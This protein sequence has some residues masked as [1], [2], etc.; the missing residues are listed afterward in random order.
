MKFLY[1]TTKNHDPIRLA[2]QRDN[3]LNSQ[4]FW[5][6]MC[7]VRIHKAYTTWSCDKKLWEA[8]YLDAH[9]GLSNSFTNEKG[10]KWTFRILP[11]YEIELT[12]QNPISRSIKEC[13]KINNQIKTYQMSKNS[14]LAYQSETTDMLKLFKNHSI[15][16]DLLR[17][18]QMTDNREII[19]TIAY[20]QNKAQSTVPEIQEAC[21]TAILELEG[22]MLQRV[23]ITKDLSQMTA[24]SSVGKTIESFGKE[25]ESTEDVNISQREKTEKKISD[26]LAN[27]NTSTKLDY[28][29]VVNSF[30]DEN[31]A[32]SLK[33]Q[34]LKSGYKAEVIIGA[35]TDKPK[36]NGLPKQYHVILNSKSSESFVYSTKESATEFIKA[37]PDSFSVSSTPKIVPTTSFSASFHK[38][39]VVEKKKEEIKETTDKPAEEIVTTFA[40]IPTLKELGIECKKLIKNNKAPAALQLAEKHLKSGNYIPNKEGKKAT[41]KND[42]DIA[43]WIKVLTDNVKKESNTEIKDK[44]LDEIKEKKEEPSQTEKVV[45]SKDTT[46]WGTTC[47]TLE[48]EKDAIDDFIINIEGVIAEAFDDKDELISEELHDTKVQEVEKLY[49]EFFKNRD[50]T[51]KQIGK[52][53]EYMDSEEIDRDVFEILNGEITETSDQTVKTLE[54]AIKDKIENG[55]DLETILNFFAKSLVG[56]II[57]DDE[58][59]EYELYTKLHLLVLIEELYNKVVAI[60]AKPE[61][62]KVETTV[63]A[64]QRKEVKEI[65]AT[66][67]RNNGTKKDL[68]DHNS[69]VHYFSGVNKMIN[70]PINAYKDHIR[71]YGKLEDMK[72]FL[73]ELY[74]E[75]KEESNDQTTYPLKDFLNVIKLDYKNNKTKEDCIKDSLSL[76]KSDDNKFLNL[77]GENTTIYFQSDKDIQEYI[78]SVYETEQQAK[79]KLVDEAEEQAIDEES[80]T[81]QDESTF[82]SFNE[83]RSKGDKLIKKGYTFDQIVAWVEKNTLNKPLKEQAKGGTFET[84]EKVLTFTKGFFKD[85]YASENSEETK[86]NPDDKLDQE[87]DEAIIKALK[88]ENALIH[89]VTRTIQEKFKTSASLKEVHD[90]TKELAKTHAIDIWDAYLEKQKEKKNKNAQEVNTEKKEVD[91]KVVIEKTIS[92]IDPVMWEKYK[93]STSFDDLH[94]VLTELCKKEETDKA[95]SLC[96]QVIPQ[97]NIE[98]AKDWEPEQITKWFNTT[99]LN[100]KSETTNEKVEEESNIEKVDTGDLNLTELGNSNNKKAFRK[101]L[102]ELMKV[103]KDDD[104]FRKTIIKFVKSNENEGEYLK[105]IHN[106]KE[107]DIHNMITRAKKQ[108]EI[109]N[110]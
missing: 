15:S 64:I 109:Q 98:T 27:N 79:E 21:K 9:C 66:L 46:D 43:S 62:K 76:V 10:E 86:K 31:M 6:S 58:G 89:T 84:K 37:L 5:T 33:K 4:K 8:Q 71:T 34:L 14:N 7:R 73:E 40:E 67:V 17:D 22:L 104:S 65:V 99:Y 72:E 2:N 61:T 90:R 55:D 51:V 53:K 96:L 42:K 57:K 35:S 81:N 56:K 101:A 80:D 16:H 88:T 36:N 38:E 3:R 68:I 74:D 93:D 69:D 11:H 24:D 50:Y 23:Q 18:L 92:A 83:I 44:R 45:E 108:V 82:T 110:V 75:I 39:K 1:P 20:W 70:K 47:D 28:Y 30:S 77:V 102:E 32:F 26:K 78:T 106:N 25:L 59:V 48:T 97:G 63:K 29:I 91:N 95:L 85:L 60:P 94:N 103:N 105:A 49:V 12:Q 19:A 54:G 41:E 87:M 107:E 52:L 13:I 100:E